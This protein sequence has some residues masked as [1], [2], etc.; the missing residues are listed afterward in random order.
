MPQIVPNIDW[1]PGLQPR[2]N[3]RLAPVLLTLTFARLIL[4]G[5]R[6]FPY[7][8]LTPMALSLRVPRSTVEAALS[9][10]WATGSISPLGRILNER[11]VRKRTLVVDVAW[12]SVR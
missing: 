5:A 6:R 2:Q 3:T 4:N 7:A 1:I 8:I 9:L 11:V 12:P 10:L